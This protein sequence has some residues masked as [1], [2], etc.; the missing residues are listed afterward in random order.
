MSADPGQERFRYRAYSVYAWGGPLLIAGLGVLL[1]NLP[2]L[3]DE[4]AGGL[5]RPR[6]GER[7]CW[8][9]GK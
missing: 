7:R 4:F 6:F 3:E 2:Y 5:I 8:F 1:D 9:Y